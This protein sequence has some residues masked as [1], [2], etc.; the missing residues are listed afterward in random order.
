MNNSNAGTA[1]SLLGLTLRIAHTHGIHRACPPDIPYDR[2][3]RRSRIWWAIVWQ[4]S[5][6]G[7]S[8]DRASAAVHLDTNT[9]LPPQYFGQTG[10]YHT[11]MYDVCKVGLE[12]VSERARL[13]SPRE[14]I[15][16]ITEHRESMARIVSDAAEY[17][18]DSRKCTTNR[19]TIEHWGLYLHSSYIMAELCRPAISPNA[20]AELVRL[21]RSTC[22]D[23]L[24]NTVEAF[25]GLNNIVSS[26]LN[27][28]IR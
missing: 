13:M 15:A 3:F 20:D 5:L 4:E 17:L 19:E 26:V 23:N 22:I 21:F 11:T 10:A 27:E 9:M 12:I 16:R 1:W 24:T 28:A 14:Q 2:V 25:L 18:R 7:I 6:L 8:Y